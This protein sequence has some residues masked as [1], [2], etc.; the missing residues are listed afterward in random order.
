MKTIKYCIV[1]FCLVQSWNLSAQNYTE[2]S[3]AVS[4][5][6]QDFYSWYINA[7]KQ[8]SV[9]DYQPRF[10]TTTKG[11]TTLDYVIY[12]ENLKKYSFSESL[13]TREKLTY[14]GCIKNLEKVSYVDFKKKW[15]D[16]E[17]F[18]T[19]GCDFSNYYRWT[20]GQEMCDGITI[21]IVEI[22]SNKA[23]VNGFLYNLNVDDNTIH[24]SVGDFEMDLEKENDV[25]KITDIKQ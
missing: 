4:K 20:G 24:D 15:L 2:D 11:M 3:T 21:S 12:I 10:A 23:K 17:Q 6:T 14:E 9:V 7:V 8:K 5:I 13:I 1:L 18:E 16:L 19:A 22:N 25:W